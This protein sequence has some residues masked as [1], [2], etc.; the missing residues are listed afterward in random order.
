MI[1]RT[2]R[3]SDIEAIYQLTKAAF[4][5]MAYSD[6]TEQDC[7]NAL[8]DD[9][10]LTLSLVAEIDD[11]IVGHVAFS[12]VTLNG[13]PDGWFG[14][15]PISVATTHQK[16]GIGSALINHGLDWLKSQNAKGCVLIGDPNYYA[17]FGFVSNGD[18][19]YH[20]L[21]T[22]YVQWLGFDG[23]IASGKLIFSRGLEP[24]PA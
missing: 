1:L 6:G 10:D 4:A 21:P 16:S 9:G 17:R 7:I 24:K 8:R 12:P 15:G 19:T 20:D 18:L 13:T 14:L 2:E 11:K 5:P 3:P 23:H 22:E